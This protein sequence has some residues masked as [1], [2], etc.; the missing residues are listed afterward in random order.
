MKNFVRMSFS[1]FVVC[2][3]AGGLLALV[4]RATR[5]R[6]AENAVRETREALRE[7]FTGGTEFNEAVKEKQWEVFNEGEK[8]GTVLKT[9]VQGYSGKISIM[10]GLDSD[11]HIT[12]VK[13]L[14]HSETPGLGAKITL[15]SFLDQYRNKKQEELYLKRDKPGGAIDAI[16]AATISS[17]AVTNRMR[18]AVKSFMKGEAP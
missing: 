7:V 18:S 8:V 17:R 11:N 2:I 3:A 16:T 10:F 5:D 12:G 1:L 6:I 14:N 4:N 9:E 13:I 15:S